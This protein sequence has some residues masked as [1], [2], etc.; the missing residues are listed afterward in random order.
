MN[1]S[2][3]ILTR[4]RFAWLPAILLA[5][6]VNYGRAQGLWLTNQ[7]M[8]LRFQ[9]D[10]A[11]SGTN[12][13][14]IVLTY[15]PGPVLVSNHQVYITGHTNARR[16]IPANPDFAFLGP[17]GAPVWILPQTQD[18]LRPYLGISAEDIPDGVFDNPMRMELVAVEGPGNFFAYSVSGAGNPPNVKMMFTNGVVSPAHR[19]AETLIGSHEHNNWAF[20][21]NGLYR[22]TFR[23]VGSPAGTGTNLV[24]RD[25]AFAFQLLPLR[26][27]E[28]WVSTNWLPATASDIAGPGADPDGDRV[29]NVMEYA[30]GLNP[31]EPSTNGFPAASLVTT[32]GQTYGALTFTRVKGAADLV[33]EPSARSTLTGG[34]W[35]VLTNV[36]TVMDHGA[37][38]TVTVRGDEPAGAHAARFLQLRVSLNYP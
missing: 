19:I 9:Y 6:A 1:T 4:A 11:A 10:A 13:L 7:H 16:T 14:N 26:P 31:N 30:L 22:V 5:L 38:E 27:W 23:C 20:S 12:Q 2:S 28:N 8:D 25:V 36:M 3:P 21:T 24:G 29:V 35:T 34:A 33:Y 32:N 18:P 17:A 37:T 15:D